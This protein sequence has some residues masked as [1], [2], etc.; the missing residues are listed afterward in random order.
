MQQENRGQPRH[1]GVGGAPPWVPFGTLVDTT[2]LTKGFTS[3]GISQN[4]SAAPV[5]E[6]FEQNRNAV[7][8][9]A[10]A[11][12]EIKKFQASVPI[13]DVNHETNER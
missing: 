13:P 12:G 8:A 7:I 4:E 6:E 9:E 10:K 3:M 5:S 1:A 2:G 11:A